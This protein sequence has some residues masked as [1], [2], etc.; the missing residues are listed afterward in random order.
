MKN[1][2]YI[3]FIFVFIV[4]A[5]DNNT[6]RL[7][8][9]EALNLID[10][11]SRVA[12]LSSSRDKDNFY[13]LFND[14]ASIYNDLI[15]S[16]N[17]NTSQQLTP[18]V[19]EMY[20]VVNRSSQFYDPR[21][22]NLYI[23]PLV[24]NNKNGN[25]FIVVKKDVQSWL[26]DYKIND[27]YLDYSDEF[28]L[29]IN[30]EYNYSD[31]LEEYST[32]IT[33]I[34]T[35]RPEKKPNIY[36]FYEKGAG[37]E[38]FLSS[39]D[40]LKRRS[41]G[42]IDYKGDSLIY[43]FEDEKIDATDILYYN[44]DFRKRGKISPEPGEKISYD[45]IIYKPKMMA[46]AQF[47]FLLSKN[48]NIY[49]FNKFYQNISQNTD[50][51]V[52]GTENNIWQG[53]S[54]EFNSNRISFMMYPIKMQLNSKLSLDGGLKF[55]ANLS[56]IEFNSSSIDYWYKETDD[57]DIPYNRHISL[58][59]F[60]E[61]IKFN[62]QSIFISLK[63]KYSNSQNK[64]L[65]DDQL[66]SRRIKFYPFLGLNI[67]AFKHTSFSSNSSGEGNI[68]GRYDQYYGVEIT[69]VLNDFGPFTFESNDN[70][71]SDNN[72]NLGGKYKIF[73]Q[74]ISE[75][76]LGCDIELNNFG[77]GLSLTHLFGSNKVFNDF[78][79]DIVLLESE[80]DVN[81]ITDVMRGAELKNTF[82]NVNLNFKF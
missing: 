62:S 43:I 34:E 4:N 23:S 42:Q 57:N 64:L 41:G 49:G 55:S 63:V 74:G 33:S 30:I 44:P 36:V 19:K 3:L 8:N 52:L 31:E 27:Q 75:V 51:V 28:L 65:V 81:S 20:R 5:Q 11:F 59:E 67:S 70:N 53:L 26:D 50:L 71:I 72:S 32:K 60:N 29:K 48:I 78:N 39:P 80:N 13:D 73:N 12:D 18:Y 14:N 46:T 61:T 76:N 15:T 22:S 17:F 54:G 77:I 45:K 21:F 24:G 35:E 25:L 38:K 56:N 7:V 10:N 1:L 37:G 40:L 66:E 47:G 58:T 82:F 6:I 68:S 9:M 16:K 2:V 79:E 69:D